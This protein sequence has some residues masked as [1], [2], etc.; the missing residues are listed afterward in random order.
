MI[1]RLFYRHP[2][3]L[4]TEHQ[5]RHPDASSPKRVVVNRMLLEGRD[6]VVAASQSVRQALILSEGL[7]PDQVRVIYNSIVPTPVTGAVRDGRS[8]RR[9]SGTSPRLG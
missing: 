3:V 1:A 4:L 5:R 8:L 6:Q 9:E 2:P 7:L